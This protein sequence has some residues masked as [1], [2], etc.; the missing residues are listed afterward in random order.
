MSLPEPVTP[1]GDEVLNDAVADARCFFGAVQVIEYV[2][3][4]DEGAV[5]ILGEGLWSPF[6]QSLV[7]GDGLFRGAECLKW[8]YFPV[9][10]YPRKGLQPAGEVGLESYGVGPGE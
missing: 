3:L 2:G 6:D 9:G 7:D 10:S 4:G 1:G 8:L 5:Q